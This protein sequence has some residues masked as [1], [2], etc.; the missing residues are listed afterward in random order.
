MPRFHATVNGNVPFT[1]EEELAWDAMEAQAQI[2]P[3]PQTITAFQAYAALD[4]AG[5]LNSVKTLMADPATSQ[6]AKLAWEKA[7]VFE[8]SSPILAT[9][10]TALGW[11]NAKLDELFISGAKIKA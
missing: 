8:R 2:V 5:L 7:Q 9:M 4:Q 3:V 6:T 1:A 10:A 11:S